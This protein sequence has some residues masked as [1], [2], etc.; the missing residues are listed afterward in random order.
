MTNE[1]IA[2]AKKAYWVS[3]EDMA[4]EGDEDDQQKQ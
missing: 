2:E 1:Q 3:I 4:E